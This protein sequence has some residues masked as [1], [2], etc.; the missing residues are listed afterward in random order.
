[1]TTYEKLQRKL[2][3]T[4]RKWLVT[5]A[6]GF[7]GSHLAETLLQLNQKVVGLD[8]FSTGTPANLE[9]LQSSLSIKQRRQFKFIEG[10]ITCDADCK[11][12]CRGVDYVLHQAALGSVPRSFADPLSTHL[13]NTTGFLK[14]LLAAQ[15]AKVKR[16]VYASSS[17]V[18]GDSGP[19]PSAVENPVDHPISLYAAT[20]KANE[21]M[22]HTYSH[23]YGLHTTG[24]RFFT[25]YG[26]WGR[27]DMA[28]Y[29][30][31]EKISN[32]LPIPVFNYGKMQRDFT[33]ID[34]IIDGVKASIDKN[35]FCEIFNLG[36]NRCENL[37][38]MIALIEQSLGKK[39]VLNM[40]DIQPGD[41]KKTFADIDLSREKLE[42]KPVTSI[43]D[44]IPK[45]I[46][47]YQDYTSKQ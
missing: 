11:L 41:V 17:S 24:L 38:D 10:D 6:A 19:R 21:L 28:M 46:R 26:P 30:F 20:K 22:A 32:D 7:I 2:R 33:Y 47:W 16:V 14:I 18:Y 44:G 8:N 29:I 12:A 35:F 1:M 5:G 25:V 3:R 37:M 36:N 39:V 13:A 34:D 15:K 9:D 23:L 27:P 45:F 43:H 4:P 31:T 42:Y 40:M